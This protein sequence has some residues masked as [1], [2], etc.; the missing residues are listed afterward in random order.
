MEG[1]PSPKFVMIR[2]I[3]RFCLPL[4]LLLTPLAAQRSPTDIGD[5]TVAAAVKTIPVRVSA[6]PEDLD[7][8]AN[9][10]FEVHGRYR[11]VA[12]DPLFDIRFT[13]VAGNRVQV[14]VSRG[15]TRVMSRAVTGTSLRNALLRAADLVV[16]ETSDLQGF[17]ASQLAFIG[18]RTGATE[19]YTSDLFFG[20]VRQL[21]SDRA[22]AMS[23]HWSP[24]GT[25]L[26]YTSFHRSNGA[27]LFEIDM[28][29]MQRTSFVSFKG[30]N[31]SGR[32]SP[33]GSKVA[34]VLSGEG[35]P[36][37]YTAN[38][39][40]RGVK[41]ITR[42]SGVESSPTFSP[43]GRQLLFTS[44]MA[45]GP[46]LYVM[47]VEGGRASRLPTNISRYCAEP[48]W[49]KGD[50]NKIAFTMRIG[51]G[52]QIGLYDRSTR[53]AATQVSKAPQDAVEP[54]WLADGR[55]L[56]YTARSPNQRSIWILDTES[57]KATQ[58]SSRSLGPA[59]QAAVVRP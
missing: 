19:V 22:S 59:S 4:T 41:R 39:N 12:A 52:F 8:L 33:D 53:A 26:L 34:M 43:D 15:T 7:Q 29:S 24:D 11:R 3:F 21:T 57:G 10:A 1:F 23:P 27:D 48:D 9:F 14:D 47:P 51:S 30:T 49:S 40:G 50:P 6:S 25:K 2:S 31:Q 44:D 45:G 36:E 46:Q 58:L 20:G 42:T 32:Y 13:A 35:N 18:T 37:V 17:F 38:A 5:I 56:L 28:R 55:H 54:A 16:E